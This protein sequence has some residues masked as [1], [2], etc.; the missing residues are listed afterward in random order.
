MKLPCPICPSGRGQEGSSIVDVVPVDAALPKQLT[1]FHPYLPASV[2]VWT[3]HLKESGFGAVLFCV[4]FI[5]TTDSFCCLTHMMGRRY[6]LNY[7]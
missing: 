2:S 5:G 7:I 3:A 6:F 1:H 4:L